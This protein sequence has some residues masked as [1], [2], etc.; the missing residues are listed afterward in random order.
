MRTFRKTLNILFAFLCLII[1]SCEPKSQSINTSL[2]EPDSTNVT[3]KEDSI[4]K[5][6]LNG[7][8][9]MTTFIRLAEN[10]YEFIHIE[11]DYVTDNIKSDKVKELYFNTKSLN[12]ENREAYYSK[13]ISALPKEDIK[14]HK[15]V[16]DIDEV[17]DQGKGGDGGL[18]TLATWIVD[19]P[20]K[21]NPFYSI[22]VRRN[23]Y[24]RFGICTEIGYIKI[25][26]KTNQILV[27]D[28]ET[29]EDLPLAD[30]RKLKLSR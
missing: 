4:K 20:S 2:S 5:A 16:W 13:I 21:K 29:G 30:W 10:S 27:S 14:I 1:L 28:L 3:Q 15:I 7:D 26:S 23:Y 12:K 8:Y 17:K 6:F 18:Y 24:D 19:K 11:D 9:F 22:E 25:H